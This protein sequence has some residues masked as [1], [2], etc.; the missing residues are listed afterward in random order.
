[1][2]GCRLDLAS[3]SSRTWKGWSWL[4][5]GGVDHRNLELFLPISATSEREV[6]PRAVVATT[7]TELL[8]M[9]DELSKL[10]V[11]GVE[12]FI[13]AHRASL[14]AHL[15]P[16]PLTGYVEPIASLASQAAL[17]TMMAEDAVVLEQNRE[18]QRAN[19]IFGA[20]LGTLLFLTGAVRLW[21][22]VRTA[23]SAEA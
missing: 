16:A 23:R 11:A 5:D 20:V 10:P 15:K 3:A 19:A 12:P 13:D 9:M 18:P 4:P 22:R 17:K 7:D 2:T 21:L 1:L 14:E 6:P 8:G